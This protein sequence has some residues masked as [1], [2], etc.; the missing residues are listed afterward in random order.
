MAEVLE[1]LLGHPSGAWQSTS[2]SGSLI[3]LID[4]I[5]LMDSTN[6]YKVWSKYCAMLCDVPSLG[7]PSVEPLL[8]SDWGEEQ[9]RTGM[10]S[11]AF[12][13][14]SDALEFRRC[15]TS[16]KEFCLSYEG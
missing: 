1:V 11:S 2:V 14:P 5:D 3:D 6:I 8:Q 16:I 10:L 15:R 9:R 7:C 13:L 12:V 4:L